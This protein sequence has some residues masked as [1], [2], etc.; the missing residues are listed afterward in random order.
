MKSR[1]ERRVIIENACMEVLDKYSIW[2]KL[3]TVF[4]KMAV[5]VQNALPPKANEKAIHF[6][7]NGD[8]AKSRGNSLYRFSRSIQESNKIK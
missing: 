2:G 4:A 5:P 3:C 6:R 8:F 1:D 7:R